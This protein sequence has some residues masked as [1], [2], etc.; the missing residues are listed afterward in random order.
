[1]FS[2]NDTWANLTHKFSEDPSWGSVL[3]AVDVDLLKRSHR[4]HLFE[5]HLNFYSRKMKKDRSPQAKETADLLQ[6][7]ANAVSTEVV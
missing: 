2:G 4:R 3:S 5:A 6:R 7:M 1:M